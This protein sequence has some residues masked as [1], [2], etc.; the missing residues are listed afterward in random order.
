MKNANTRRHPIKRRNAL[1]IVFALS[2]ISAIV[3]VP[4]YSARSASALGNGASDMLRSG[5]E[6]SRNHSTLTLWAGGSALASF[7][8]IPQAA[9]ETISTFAG[10]C[11]TPRSTFFVGETV[12]AKTDNVDLNYAGGRW[13]DW[14]LTGTQNTIVSGSRTTT[15][16]TTNPQTFTY[17]PNT[18]GVYK[19]EITQTGPNGEDDPQTPAVFTVVD[20][21]PMATYDSTCT[22]A[23]T[24]FVL[25]DT[26]CAKAT[27]LV[28]YRFAW[29][30]SG[31]FIRQRTDITTSPQ[32]DTFTLPST[33]TSVINGTTVDNRGEWRVNAITSRG[34]LKS[35]AFFTVKDPENPVVDLSIYKTIVGDYPVEGG[36]V[37]FSVTITNHGPDDAAN[38]HF[39]DDTFTNATFNSVTQTE[40]LPFICSGSSSADCTIAAFP[41]GSVA[42]FLLNF[43]AGTAGGNLE[44]TATVSSTS[45]EQYPADNSST[46]PPIR[47]ES[48]GAPPAC[49]LECPENI[50]A[51]ADTTENNQRG[52]HV[53]YPDPS[54]SGTCG[55]V[56]Y[57]H[58]SGSFFPVG[59][60]TVIATSTQGNGSCSFTVT[61]SDTGNP[62]TITCPSNKTAD[63]NSDCEAIVDIGTP[64]VS[65]GQNVTVHVTR[66][67]GKPMYD[68]D[69][70]G[71]NC[72][73]KNPDLPFPAGVTTITWTATSHDDQ[74][75]DSGNASCTQ[76]V[77]VNDVTPPVITA[78]DSTVPADANCQAA[79][80]D[81]SNDVSDNCS[82]AANDNSQDCVGQ[83]RITTTQDPAAG[84]LVG[85]GPHTIHVTANDGSSNNDGAGNTTQKDITF[86]VNDS[87]APTITC[88]ANVTTGNDAGQCYAMVDPGTATATDNCDSNPTVTGTRSDNQSLSSPYPVGTTTI[89]WTATDAAGNHSSCTQTVTVNDTENP[90]ITAP[91]NVTAY[92]GPGRTTCDAEVS[93]GTLGTASTNDNCP[94]VTVSRSPSGNTFPVGT[95]TVTWTATDAHGNTKTATQ[96]VTV[97]DNTPPVVT[98]PANVTAYTGPGATS[99]GT[100]V[101]DGTLGTASA[102]DNCPGVS[103]VSR[104]GVPSGN[105]FPVGTTTITYSASDAH[106][107]S[108]SATQTVTV[109]DNTPPVIS[110]PSNI[111]LEPTCPSGAI[112]T[113]TAPVGTDNCPGVTTT[114]TAGGASGS[115]FPIGTTTVTFTANDAHGNSTS[116]SFTVTVK[117]PQA[118]IQDLIN[119]VQALMDQGAL[120]QTNGQSL[121]SRLQSAL[122]YLN[123]GQTDKACD[124]L[125]EFIAKTQNFIDTNKLTSAQGQPLIDSANKIRNTLGCNNT[126]GTCT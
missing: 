69:A 85:L 78:T 39:V 66:S 19:V 37:Q 113:Y 106:G 102:T 65:G 52:T 87:T 92:T 21:P 57:D 75:N 8:P 14:I 28:G 36:P 23:R 12:C 67:D 25:G 74:G 32:T 5:S 64:T 82:C 4:I 123:N 108:S 56:S 16:I 50:N 17:A 9:S 13:V 15:L 70:N 61:V 10:D 72:T 1:I 20:A 53:S 63:A 104:T 54:A 89:T 105:F 100:F 88:P 83:H 46:A 124:K 93:N 110:C 45:T 3:V 11:T 122:D 115:V 41:K 33:Q 60:T 59:A 38:V 84:T 118:V 58:P 95:T 101:S 94:G 80:P 48:G 43:T 103:G 49:I 44:N 119:R 77:T 31:G 18:A 91:P 98:P 120:N 2:L 116:C 97:I 55:T 35:S 117:T 6:V 51:N 47:V 114:R 34:S 7:L 22:I 29:V 27:G 40:G 30:D 125:A 68:C 79:V 112:A 71:N 107:N 96:T 42:K 62:P 126:S 99:C 81:Y 109:I 90:T 76:T 111:T 24:T 26:V 86:T 121:I 73:R